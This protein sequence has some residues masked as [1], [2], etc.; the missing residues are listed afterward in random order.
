MNQTEIKEKYGW[1]KLLEQFYFQQNSVLFNEYKGSFKIKKHK[2]K[3]F[4]YFQLSRKGKGRDKYL[5]SVEP[6]DKGN[7][8]SSF[9][10]CCNILSTKLQSNFL[11]SSRNKTNIVT[12]IDLYEESLY[13][14]MRDINNGRKITTIKVLLTGVRDFKRFCVKENLKLN[15]IPSSELKTV[16]KQYITE[17]KNRKLERNSIRKYVQD[18]RYFL[19]WLCKD[20]LLG[21]MELFPSHP[22]TP[23]LQNQL[24]E[25]V[26]GTQRTFVER[27]FSEEYYQN[28]YKE[29]IKKVR[30][31]W[32][33]YC[34]EGKIERKKDKN[35][36]INQPPHFLG[37]DVVWFRYYK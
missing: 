6:R 33:E 25:L 29:C 5:C 14:E 23:K 28:V 32:D 3:Y 35:G 9:G 27:K 21:G 7:N 19:D 13:E 31:I 10:Y 18:V 34:K 37:R 16:I 24:L 4:W 22:I 8:E 17:L 15:I 1:S 11:I 30:K 12:Y 36:K 26:V 2:Y 20:K